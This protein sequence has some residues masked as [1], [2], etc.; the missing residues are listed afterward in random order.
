MLFVVLPAYNEQEALP[1][2]F[3][4]IE[5]VC[6]EIQARIIVV[7]DGSTDQTSTVVETYARKFG[8]IELVKHEYNCGLGEALRSGFQYVLDYRLKH[9]WLTTLENKEDTIPDLVVTMDADNTH[10]A[11]RIPLLIRGIRDGAD[12]VIA[13]RYA[14]GG[15]QFGLNFVRRFLSWGAGKIMHFFFPITGVRDYSCGYRA[16]RLSLLAE[17]LRQYGESLIES[18]SFAAM[19]ELLL[20]LAPL[21]HKVGEIPLQLHY[22][23]KTGASKM[24][25]LKTIWGYLLLIYR[26]KRNPWSSI[27]WIEE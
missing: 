18:R 21:S 4:D 2:L 26:L 8:N 27:E 5:T 17:G 11:D 1:A 16:Y 20:K 23:R 13:S 15:E 3:A 6:R 25:I 12:L 22:E 7:D 9:S 19:V 10:P 24:K 14:W